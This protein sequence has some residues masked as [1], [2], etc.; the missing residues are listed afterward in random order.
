MVVEIGHEV[1][2]VETYRLEIHC[3]VT[4]G[5]PAPAVTWL[6]NGLPISAEDYQILSEISGETLVM[7]SVSPVRDNGTF[8]C[9]AE[10]A[11]VGFAE[12]ETTVT[13]VGRLI[14]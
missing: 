11:G 12:R 10:V 4:R 8:T 3:T 9:K 2:V 5:N 1:T 13:V 6:H 7:E 14:M